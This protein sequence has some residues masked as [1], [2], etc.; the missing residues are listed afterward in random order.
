MKAKLI[1]EWDWYCKILSEGTEVTIIKGMEAD[2]SDVLNAP[3]GMC[4]LCEFEGSMH[5]IPATYL[6]ITDWENTDWEQRRYEI[7]KEAMLHMIDPKMLTQKYGLMAVNAVEFADS[8]IA[9]LKKTK[10]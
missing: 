9:E 5:Y 8:L 4:Y 10:K 7:A 2:A 3:Y 1:K 6:T